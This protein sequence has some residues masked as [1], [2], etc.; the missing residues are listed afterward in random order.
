MENLNFLI[1]KYRAM[2]VQAK[3]SIWYMGCNILQKGI[4][5][6]VIPI[7]TRLLTTTEYGQ[8]TV[9]QSWRDIILIFATLNLYCGVFTK[10]M[11]DYDDD[12][13]V[14]TSSMQGLGSVITTILFGGYLITSGLWSKLLEMSK[15]TMILL[16][17]YYYVYPAFSFWSVR[18]RVEYKYKKMVI[19]TLLVS[20]LT[21]LLSVVML[22][23]T[24]LRENA[25]IFGYLIVQIIVGVFFY[26]YNFWKGKV[27]FHKKYWIHA[28]K[29]N[30]PLIP[31]Y[32]S[33]IVL[34]QADRIM[35][36]QY[37]GSAEAG[38]YG[39]AYQVSMA[40][41]IVISAVNN[42]MVPWTYEKLKSAEYSLIRKNFRYLCLFMMLMTIGVI[43][44]A[45][46]VITILSTPEYMDAVWVIPAVAVSVYFT[47]CYG[48]FSNVEFYYG[49]TKYVM[50][51]SSVGAILNIMLNAIFIPIFGF[52]AAGYTTMV[53]Y[54]CFMIMHYFFMNK[55]CK[56]NNIFENIYDTKFMTVSCILITLIGGIC[57][58]VYNYVVIRY[59]II[60]IGL[61]ITIMYRDRVTA[62]WIAVKRG[63]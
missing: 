52:V 32:L 36:G 20:I 40:L 5:F 37:C 44:I 14:Y 16:F 34:G 55:V 6:I 35:I 38:I 59:L 18:Q 58:S 30:I 60:A 42:A 21:P 54:L 28:L 29:F 48:L 19:V 13:D 3:A 8:Y 22:Y 50:V 63:K 2:S 24:P 23:L 39:L 7:Y 61:T 43:L 1:S 53:C 11:V 47:Y 27:F 45:P 15:V 31:H 25:V 46:E 49:A 33:L 51:A 4:S 57:L 26:V 9:F 41:N 62:F 12:R 10:A 56:K 17:V